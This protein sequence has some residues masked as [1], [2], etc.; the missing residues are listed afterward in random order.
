MTKTSWK[1][2][3]GGLLGTIGTAV[4]GFS[5]DQVMHAIGI[6]VGGIGMLV[7]GLAARDNSVTSEQAGAK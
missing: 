2:T 6:I 7:L 3:V 1:T 5:T 4:G